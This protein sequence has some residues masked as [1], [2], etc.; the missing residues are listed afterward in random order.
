MRLTVCSLEIISQI[1]QP[2]S[3]D[4]LSQKI[5]QQYFHP[6]RSAKTNRLWTSWKLFFVSISLRVPVSIY[7]IKVNS[8]VVFLC[9]IVKPRHHEDPTKSARSN[10]KLHLLGLIKSVSF[11]LKSSSNEEALYSSPLG[12][13]N[14]PIQYSTSKSHSKTFTFHLAPSL[15]RLHPPLNSHVVPK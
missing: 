1:S 9:D 11:D 8:T 15:L 7:F 14:A 6:A 10:T 13:F 3:S 2:A 4:F 5:S 12:S